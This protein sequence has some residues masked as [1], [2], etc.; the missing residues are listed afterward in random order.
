MSMSLSAAPGSWESSK[1]GLGVLRL[2]GLEAQVRV[3]NF[4]QR[5]L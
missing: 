3:W 4:A 5:A 1:P 2:H